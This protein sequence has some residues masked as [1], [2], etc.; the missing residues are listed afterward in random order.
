MKFCRFGS[1]LLLLAPT[2]DAF[3]HQSRPV[4]S[5]SSSTMVQMAGADSQ[6]IDLGLTPELQRVTDAFGS[7]E[8]E[9]V[10][11]KQLLYMGQNTKEANNMPESSKIAKNKVPGCLSTVYVDGNAEFNDE[12]GDYVVNFIGDSDGLLTRGLVAL[13]VRCLSGNTA[14]AIQ[15]VDPQ[16]IKKAK[17]EQSLTPG[18]NNGFLNMLRVMK[19]KAVEFDAAARDNGGAESQAEAGE[20]D[21][22]APATATPSEESSSEHG[23]KYNAIVAKLQSLKPASLE[24]I[25]NSHQHAG[26]A[27]NDVDGESHFELKIV[28]EAFDGLNLVKRH[29]LIYMML[30]DLMPQIHALQ[31][32]SL[33]PEEAESRN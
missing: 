32:Q 3:T 21:D 17:I 19:Q 16:F 2:S 9:Q 10:R 13:L 33:T 14:E 11:Y 15:K 25:D 12:I 22:D 6:E 4:T 24:L 1:I 26:D 7:I 18:R 31:I 8:D 29:Q 30:G 28:A 20:S 27:G 5:V 23:P